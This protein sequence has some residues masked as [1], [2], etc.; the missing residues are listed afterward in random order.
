V[1]VSREIRPFL[2]M[3][4]ELENSL[5][6]PVTRIFLDSAYRPY[7]QD[8]KFR[9]ILEDDF[10]LFIAVG[11]RA[12]S[13]LLQQKITSHIIYGMIVHPELFI[14]GYN[15]NVSGISLNIFSLTQLTV[16]KQVFP[17]IRGIGVLYDPEN[18]EHWF[19]SARILA[20]ANNI[21]LIPLEISDNHMIQSVL[22][23]KT[24]N[25]DAVLFIPDATVISTT[26]IK[27]AIKQL[28]SKKIPAIG[29]NSFFSESG[30]VL[31][32]VIDY[33]EVG[34]Q[35]ANQ[36]NSFLKGKKKLS[37]GA[38]FKVSL[39]QKVIQL[40]GLKIGSNL[41]ENVEFIK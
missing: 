1:V 9:E 27:H 3:V 15:S 10:T 37:V 22:D 26:V 41:P 18:N 5:D 30:A 8:G 23:E 39:N 32:F 14:K 28:L 40:L 6:F 21:N 34:K 4:D 20:R 12:L 25:I 33:R 31:S 2:M 17:G 11:P 13:Y 16:I 24:N 36:A 29:Y 35:V 38:T 19:N 7:G